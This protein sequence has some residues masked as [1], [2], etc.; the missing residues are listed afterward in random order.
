MDRPPRHGL[1]GL[2]FLV[3]LERSLEFIEAAPEN[4]EALGVTMWGRLGFVDCVPSIEI[5]GFDQ[6]MFDG[7]KSSQDDRVDERIV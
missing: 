2:L 6:K 5:P 3:T 4:I 7:L 1:D